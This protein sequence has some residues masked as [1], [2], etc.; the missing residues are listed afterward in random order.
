MASACSAPPVSAT[1]PHCDE[2]IS[3]HKEKRHHFLFGWNVVTKKIVI[4]T[5][6]LEEVFKKQDI[7]WLSEPFFIEKQK[8]R[9]QQLELDHYK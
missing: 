7:D 6:N 1:S 2:V 9:H 8:T 4:T 5:E 3:E